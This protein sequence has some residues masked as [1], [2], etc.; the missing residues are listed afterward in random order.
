MLYLNLLWCCSELYC[1]H[2]V[3]KSDINILSFLLWVTWSFF[4][5][6]Q[7]YFTKLPIQYQFCQVHLGEQ[8]NTHIQV[9]LYFQKVFL[10]NNYNV[11]LFFFQCYTNTLDL[12]CPSFVSITFY[13]TL[14]TTNF[15]SFWFYDCFHLFPQWA[16]LKLQ[17]NLFSLKRASSLG[18]TSEMMLCF[19][20]LS[21]VWAVIVSCLSLFCVYVCV[22]FCFE[23]SNSY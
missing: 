5:E 19:L 22:H 7:R 1:L 18:F 23:F 10:E 20:F 12:F 21:R 13:I 3:K 15:I 8:L 6:L 17:S 16:L 9:F 4:L 14:F 2:V 11:M